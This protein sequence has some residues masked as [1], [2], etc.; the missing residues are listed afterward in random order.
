[1]SQ[2]L[3]PLFIAIAA[4]ALVLALL[5][6]W[7]S[8]RVL[9]LAEPGALDESSSPDARLGLINEKATLLKALKE[10]EQEREFGK[11]S[12]QDYEALNARYRERARHV[13]RALDSQLGDFRKQAEALVEEQL[14]KESSAENASPDAIVDQKAPAT[15]THSSRVSCP[16][17][18]IDNEADAAFCKKCGKP[19]ASES[20]ADESDVGGDA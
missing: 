1:V 10:I 20:D 12:E 9:L 6:F 17:C 16:F 7:Q 15:D 3:P 13:L 5:A 18:Q 4:L 14:A 11:I 19:I 2:I 8:L